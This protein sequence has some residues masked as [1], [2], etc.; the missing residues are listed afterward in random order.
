MTG[1]VGEADE[2]KGWSGAEGMVSRGGGGEWDVRMREEV[3]QQGIGN[4]G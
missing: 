4:E 1:G 3:R 2:R